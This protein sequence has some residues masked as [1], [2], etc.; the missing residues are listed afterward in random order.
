M[1][2]SLFDLYTNVES[3]KEL[4]D[5]LESK[6]MAEDSLSK[7]FMDFKHTLKHDKDDLSL[8]QLGSLAYR[9]ISKGAGK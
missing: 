8:V 7:K 5:S 9:E 3:A 6:Y 4:W 2:D 1:S